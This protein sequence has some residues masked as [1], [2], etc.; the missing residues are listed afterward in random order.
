MTIEQMKE[1]IIEVYPGEIWRKRV[2]RMR[3]WQ[4]VSVYKTFEIN[5][6][7]K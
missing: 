7:F 2:E 5:G 1:R 3:D 6:K 4:I